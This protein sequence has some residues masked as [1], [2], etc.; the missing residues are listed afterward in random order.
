MMPALL[1]SQP[2]CHPQVAPKKPP[3]RTA[4]R[5]GP[6]WPG[7]SGLQAPALTSFFPRILSSSDLMAVILIPSCL[8]STFGVTNLIPES[9]SATPGRTRQGQVITL[10][11]QRAEE[12]LAI[13]LGGTAR[14][15]SRPQ[16][17]PSC[18]RNTCPPGP[19]TRNKRKKG[20]LG[21]D[22]LG[23]RSTLSYYLSKAG[24]DTATSQSPSPHLKEACRT[25][26]FLTRALSPSLLP[27]LGPPQ[28]SQL[29]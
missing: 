24:I 17:P 4:P 13:V 23:G 10:S 25:W 19:G 20:D 15:G 28:L 27:G 22:S 26:L 18:R 29:D 8:D 5:R 1:R 9:L 14:Q 11:H 6:L 2:P 3:W 12:G 21:T 7:C 16:A